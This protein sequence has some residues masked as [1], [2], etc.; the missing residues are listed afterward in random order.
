MR[1]SID[2]ARSTPLQSRAE[3]LSHERRR[4]IIN[5]ALS[6]TCCRRAMLLETLGV[7]ASD[8]SGCD[9]CGAKPWT[10]APEKKLICQTIR[11]NQRRLSRGQAARVLIGR[12]SAEIRSKGSDT[13]R[14]F[15][16]LSD[17]ELE[18]AEGA[19]E[20]LHSP[21][22]HL[23]LKEEIHISTRSSYSLL[24]AEHCL[25]ARKLP[26]GPSDLTAEGSVNTF[27]S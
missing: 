5:Y 16:C 9:V 7:E 19:I 11:W 17:W 4:S 22:E 26:P 13:L 21:E 1:T 10:S 15:G 3:Q 20:T 6:T 18:D 24:R 8:C 23:K 25:L 14:G 2:S 27:V 12:R